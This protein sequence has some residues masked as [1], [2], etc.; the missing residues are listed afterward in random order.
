M[1]QTYAAL[2]E[3][4]AIGSVVHHMSNSWVTKKQ[5]FFTQIRPCFLLLQEQSSLTAKGNRGLMGGF[6]FLLTTWVFTILAKEWS[7]KIGSSSNF[8][9][10]VWLRR[11]TT[12]QATITPSFVPSTVKKKKQCSLLLSNNLCL[13]WFF[14]CSVSSFLET[15]FLCVGP[16]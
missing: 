7:S 4:R 6:A 13:F 11:A 14:S 5:S 12:W 3:W 10:K 16:T 2:C 1:W 15:Y 9:S 8:E